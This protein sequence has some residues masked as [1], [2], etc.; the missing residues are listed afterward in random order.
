MEADAIV[1]IAKD[2]QDTGMKIAVMVDD[3]DS[4]A[5]KKLRDEFRSGIEKC[6][7]LNHAKKISGTIFMHS[8][9]KAMQ[10]SPRR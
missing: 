6:S 7:N 9:P 2:L 4:S 8:K 10:N 3:D 1:Q 5:I